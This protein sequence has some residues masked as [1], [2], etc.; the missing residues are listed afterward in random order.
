MRKAIQTGKLDYSLAGIQYKEEG[1]SISWLSDDE[2]SE[3][4]KVYDV[5]E[6]HPY[7]KKVLISCVQD[8]RESDFVCSFQ[9]NF[10]NGNDNEHLPS[11]ALFKLMNAGFIAT[12]PIHFSSSLTANEQVAINNYYPLPS[13]HLFVI[14]PP[15]WSNSL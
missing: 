10:N 13:T 14:C 6:K 9:K 4:G 11:L 7:G 2:F 5:I 3:E 15:P 8:I 12:L 1:P